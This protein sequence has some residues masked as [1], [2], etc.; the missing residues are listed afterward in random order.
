M[1][2]VVRRRVGFLLRDLQDG[3]MPAMP[4]SRPMPLIGPNCH[5]LRVNHGSNTWRVIYQIR[6]G[7]VYVGD[8]FRKKTQ[9]T[10][11]QVID[12]C[13]KRFAEQPD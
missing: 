6:D 13:R 4:T 7:V 12:Q 5:E 10:P 1:S 8:T 2:D 3:Q 9:A 11:K